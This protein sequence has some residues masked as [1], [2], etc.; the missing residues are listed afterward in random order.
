M[1]ATA[2]ER[3]RELAHEATRCGRVLPQMPGHIAWCDAVTAAIEAALAAAERAAFRAGWEK[4]REA[5]RKATCVACARGEPFKRVPIHAG[6]MGAG[7][8]PETGAFAEVHEVF[9]YCSAD[10]IRTLE[11]P[12]DMK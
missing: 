4:G 5:A 8:G 9:G 1:T 7:V 2:R 6:I 12:E 3:A 10:A 11:P